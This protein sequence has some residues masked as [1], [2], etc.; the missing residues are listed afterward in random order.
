M[1]FWFKEMLYGVP[2]QRDRNQYRY[3]AA[4]IAID[5]EKISKSW[6]EL[7][8]QACREVSCNVANYDLGGSVE[9]AIKAVQLF[10]AINFIAKQSYLSPAEEEDFCSVLLHRICDTGVCY[11]YDNDCRMYLD[12]YWEACKESITSIHNIGMV[13]RFSDDIAAYLTGN[14][15]SSPESVII[16]RQFPRFILETWGYLAHYFSDIK[17]VNTLISEYESYRLP[18]QAMRETLLDKKVKVNEQKNLERYIQK[19]LYSDR[20]PLPNF[21]GHTRG[22]RGK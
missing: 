14:K 9:Q 4:Y 7:C 11:N 8:V 21:L 18:S 20:Y 19:K 6:F 16:S 2:F 17:T 5:F 3:N 22:S 10:L 15:G 12:R 1:S 13:E